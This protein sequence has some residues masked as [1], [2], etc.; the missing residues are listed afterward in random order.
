MKQKTEIEIELNETVAYSRRSERFQAYCAQCESQ[1]EMSTPQI[2]AI[3]MHATERE[4]YRM[5]ESN[6][7]H[8]VETDRVVVC[9]SSLPDLVS[10]L[11]DMSPGSKVELPQSIEGSRYGLR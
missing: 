6:Q 11:K 4:I 9:L 10:K 3:L 1:V 2:A 5:V 7:V 8:F